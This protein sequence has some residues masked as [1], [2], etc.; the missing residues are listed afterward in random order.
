MFKGLLVFRRKKFPKE[1]GERR[2]QRE[3]K[4]ERLYLILRGVR[5]FRNGARRLLRQEGKKEMPKNSEKKMT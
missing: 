3:S 5:F 1:G 2:L 4:Y